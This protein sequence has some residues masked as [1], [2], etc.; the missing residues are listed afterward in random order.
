M[1]E[2]PLI[3]NMVLFA[4]DGPHQVTVKE[5]MQRQCQ[6]G[7]EE[8]CARAQQLSV[9][10]EAQKRLE[11]RAEAFWRD[12]NTADLMFDQKKPD[13]EAAYPLVMHDY[14]RMEAA[15][16]HT[17]TLLE[18]YLPQCARHYHNHWINKKMWWPAWDDGTPDWPSI[19]TFIVDHYYG[20][21]VK[22][23]ATYM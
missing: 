15:A 9:D 6:A 7:N 3:L 10:L 18:D 16:G 4:A 22:A 21:C 1:I 17:Q 13:L 5:F 11:Q 19:Y 14:Q 8:A 23:G 12:V 2:L 20:F